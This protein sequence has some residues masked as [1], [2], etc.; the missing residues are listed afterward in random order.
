LPVIEATCQY[1]QPARYDDELDIRTKG[2]TVS[3]VRIEFEYEVV[4][5]ADGVLAAV[6]RTL[7]AA[8]AP[9]GRPCRLPAGVRDLLAGAGAAPEA[10]AP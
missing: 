3:P 6:G 4:R 7:H 2:T 5:R 9:D 8:V 1:R 10:P